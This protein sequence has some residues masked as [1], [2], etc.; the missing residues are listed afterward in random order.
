MR[1]DRLVR[2]ALAAALTMGAGQVF[3]GP[4]VASAQDPPAPAPPAAPAATGPAATDPG[5]G[6]GL[7]RQVSLTPQEM[8]TQAD[9]ALSRLEGGRMS[10][11]KQLAAARKERD[12]VKTLCLNDKLN[13]L[14]VALR[15]ATERRGALE[16]AAKRGDADLANHEFTILGVLR[17]RGDQLIVEANQCIGEEAGFAGD[18]AVSMTVDGVPDDDADIPDFGVIVD[19]P[20]CASCYL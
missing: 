5:A 16:L 3:F 13:Q 6:A 7:A 15:S 20:Q 18:S 1:R 10:V 2:L 19:P 12:V 8:V 9:A 17:Q 14:D 4:G 11:A